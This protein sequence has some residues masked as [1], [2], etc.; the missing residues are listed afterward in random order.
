[1]VRIKPGGQ[2]TGVWTERKGKYSSQDRRDGT[3][4]D[5]VRDERFSTPSVSPPILG[6]KSAVSHVPGRSALMRLFTGSFEHALDV[7]KRPR[8][9]SPSPRLGKVR[10]GLTLENHLLPVP[11]ISG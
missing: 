9:K 10:V 4:V 11:K 5:G 6:E 7:K 8:S 1:M 2:K 3:K